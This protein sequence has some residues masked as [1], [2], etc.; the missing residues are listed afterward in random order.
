MKFV[1]VGYPKCGQNSLVYKLQADYNLPVVDELG[2]PPVTRDECIWR[3]NAVETC[4]EWVEK[5]YRLA[6]IDREPVSRIWSTYHDFNFYAKM[7]FDEYLKFDGYSNTY[8]EMNP[9]IQSDYSYWTGRVQHLDPLI[10]HLEDLIQDK[11]FAHRNPT[12]NGNYK[13]KK[14]KPQHKKLVEKLLG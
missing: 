6:I 12:T 1:V 9:I 13:N 11:D 7:T 8:G 2:N 10:F 3:H 14:L 5:G 4:E